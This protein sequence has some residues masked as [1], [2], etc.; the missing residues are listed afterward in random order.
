M[1]SRIRAAP[2]HQGLERAR[3]LQ[4]AYVKHLGTTSVLARRSVAR[5][6]IGASVAKTPNR[7]RVG[8]RA[9]TLEVPAFGAVGEAALGFT[10][11]P[12]ESLFKTTSTERREAT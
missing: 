12:G 9:K 3:L 7:A 8:T 5:R 2:A 11:I 6:S 1:Q 4:L 10:K